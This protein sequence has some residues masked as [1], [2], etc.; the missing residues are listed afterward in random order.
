[1]INLKIERKHKR[2]AV[3]LLC[4]ALLYTLGNLL[5]LKILHPDVKEEQISTGEY[6]RLIISVISACI[7]FA[8]VLVAL[9]KDDLRELWKYPRI[10]FKTPASSTIE[11]TEEEDSQ[12]AGDTIINATKYIS[13]IEVQ[14][15]GNL[16]TLNAEVYL[17]KLE[18]KEKNSSIAQLIETTGIPMA[19]NGDGIKTIIIPPGGKKLINLVEITAPVKVSTPNSPQTNQPAKVIIGGIDN[20][21]EYKRGTWFATFTLYAQN[22]KPTNFELEIEWSGV[23]KRRL[24]EMAG[25]LRIDIKGNK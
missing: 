9:F 20:N 24:T 15:V 6:Y 11:I 5:P 13:R 21:T 8:A 14:N 18:F 7:T 12:G 2:L 3:V 23:W 17:D 16:P 25:Q 1:M 4:S 22:H 19:W 10:I